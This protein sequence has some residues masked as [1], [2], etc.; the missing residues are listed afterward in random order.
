MSW[1][2]GHTYANY[3]TVNQNTSV[4]DVWNLAAGKVVVVAHMGSGTYPTSLTD[5]A[6]N[7]YVPLNL[8]PAS[9]FIT[10]WICVN[11]IANAA[12]QITAT[13]N[14]NDPSRSINVTEWSSSVSGFVG[15]IDSIGWGSNTIGLAKASILPLTTNAVNTLVILFGAVTA[16]GTV[17]TPDAGYTIAVQD[18]SQVGVTVYKAFS[19]VQ[20]GITPGITNNSFSILRVIGIVITDDNT[21]GGGST[22]G[23]VFAAAFG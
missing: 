3:D 12:N 13:L 4:S 11:T 18:G 6:G 1:T 20:N 16:T 23:N 7:R 10:F 21:G 8:W 19:A 9:G 15:P 17:W 5:T 14:A 22:P 2:L